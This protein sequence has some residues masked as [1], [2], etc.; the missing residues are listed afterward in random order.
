VWC[1]EFEGIVG[2]SREFR[3]VLEQVRIVAPS[4]AT[5]LITGETSIGKA[6]IANAIHKQSERRAG[7]FVKLNCAAIPA[8]LL[9]RDLF[10]YEKWVSRD[11]TLSD[12]KLSDEK[13]GGE[14]DTKD[15]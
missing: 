14:D 3:E 10:G 6:L 2:S 13:T 12:G 4:P 8:E 15:L 5:V 7:P 9:E 1:N 11:R